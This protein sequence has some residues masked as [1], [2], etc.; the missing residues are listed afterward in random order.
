METFKVLISA[1]VGSLW[2]SAYST[3]A[4]LFFIY[5]IPN[6]TTQP[7]QPITSQVGYLIIAT[8]LF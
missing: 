6:K 1:R 3:T 8:I 4:P 5:L 2:F 7:T